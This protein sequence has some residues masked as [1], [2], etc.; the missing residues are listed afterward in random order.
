MV[1]VRP[2]ACLAGGAPEAQP[3]ASR[4]PLVATALAD[5][6]PGNRG[7]CNR[8]GRADTTLETLIGVS[9]S[10]RGSRLRHGADD[11]VV[12]A[13][14]QEVA[15]RDVRELSAADW[16]ALAPEFRRE[17]ATIA[18]LVPGSPD[19]PKTIDVGSSDVGSIAIGSGCSLTTSTATGSDAR[20]RPGAVNGQLG[21]LEAV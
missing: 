1:R 12:R 21:G 9:N 11:P 20:R 5:H 13:S 3:P 19:Y 7:S 14:S 17:I 2:G 6:P 10:C 4:A 8:D 18:T 16:L 15:Q